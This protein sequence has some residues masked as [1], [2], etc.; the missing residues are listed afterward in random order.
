MS[1][2]AM[3][4]LEDIRSGRHR[5]IQPP[6][7]YAEVLAVL[8]RRTPWL[9]D[10]ALAELAEL[11]AAS[12]ADNATYM[13]A[14]DLARRSKQHLFD[15]LYHA[16]AVEQGAILVTADECYFRAASNEGAIQRLG[17]FRAM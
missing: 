16:L 1:R 10:A 7:W 11:D 15:T 9:T 2:M 5:L 13:R 3:H 8:V 6:H 12:A 14:A 4:L 17:D